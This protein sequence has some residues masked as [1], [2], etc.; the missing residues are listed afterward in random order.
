MNTIEIHR[1]VQDI[2]RG[3]FDDESLV[4]ARETSAPDIEGWDSL[5]QINLVVSMEKEFRVKFTLQELAELHN[6]GDMLDLIA[7][8]EPK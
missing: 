1:R 4:I 3:V 5:A 6:V 8:K 7:S 2:F